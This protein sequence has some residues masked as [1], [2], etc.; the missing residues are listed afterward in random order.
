MSF[1]IQLVFYLFSL[2]AF[3]LTLP[4]L[5]F[6]LI[7]VIIIDKNFPIFIQNR[8]GLNGKLIKIYKV[9]TMKYDKNKS[10][11]Y[12]TFLGNLLRL[13]KI[14][15]L[16]QLINILKG[17][18]NLIGPRPLFIEFNK[19]YKNHHV[20]RLTVKPGITGLAQIQVN[21]STSWDEKFDLDVYYIKNKSFKLDIYI[22][23][24]TLI[25]VILFIFI[26]SSRPVE[27]L[28]YK[29]DFF[30]NYIGK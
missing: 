18:M 12:V 7:L 29:T 23:F 25:K 9:T 10:L 1:I 17:D 8:S 22:I 2:F 14:D 24:K 11:K 30:D 21:D 5:I 19:Y 6:S 20:Q 27:S 4:I 26:K 3:L 15:E 28:D 16:P 13:S